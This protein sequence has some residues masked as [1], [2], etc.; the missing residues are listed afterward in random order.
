MRHRWLVITSALLIGAVACS[1]SESGTASSTQ[2]IVESPTPIRK[3]SAT[4]TPTPVP[5]SEWVPVASMN[6]GRTAYSATLL[7]DGRV[8][9]VGGLG[10]EGT[11]NSVEIYDPEADTWT[12]VADTIHSRRNSILATLADGRVVAAG[13]QDSL[14]VSTAEIFDPTRNQW[15]ELPPLNVGRESAMWVSLDDGRL[16]VFGGGNSLV[17]GTTGTFELASAEIYDPEL[18]EWILVEP[19]SQE[20]VSWE[21]W[22]KLNDGRVLLTGGDFARPIKLVQIFD[23]ATDSWEL[24]TEL[25]KPTGGG[26]TVLLPDGNVLVAGGGLRCCLTETLVFDTALETWT[27]GPEMLVKRGGHLGLNLPDGRIVFLFGLNPDFPFDD[28]Y[29]G[30]EIFDPG[31]GQQELLADFPG[32]F[33]LVNQVVVLQDGRVLIA[34]GRFGEI[35]PDGASKISYSTDVFLLRSPDR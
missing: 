16:F 23:P 27:P 32:V 20:E 33:N 21:G 12:N 26:A 5:A 7:N 35:T 17:G 8:L 34:G 15:T 28:P 2:T 13:G 25:P 19:M 3:P 18:N 1:S 22:V 24:S 4:P 11:L 29:R 31:T 6:V 14:T 9:T 30:G 10:A